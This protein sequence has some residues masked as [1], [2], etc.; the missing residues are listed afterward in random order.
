MTSKKKTVYNFAKHCLN[1]P[2]WNAGGMPTKEE[3][4]LKKLGWTTESDELEI[5]YNALRKIWRLQWL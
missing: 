3:Y 5:F 2:E 1:D 4:Y